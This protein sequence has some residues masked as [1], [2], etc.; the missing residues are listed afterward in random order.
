M[1]NGFENNAEKHEGFYMAIFDPGLYRDN[2]KVNVKHNTHPFPDTTPH[3]LSWLLASKTAANHC[4]D[5]L[6]E[7]CGNMLLYAVA[8]DSQFFSS[9]LK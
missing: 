1:W 9:K 3:T 5:A 2:V 8:V 6:I 4:S 7:L